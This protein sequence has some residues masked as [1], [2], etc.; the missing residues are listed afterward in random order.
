MLIIGIVWLAF[1]CAALVPVGVRRSHVESMLD[2]DIPI[3]TPREEAERYLTT[4]GISFITDDVNR[5]I[6]ASIRD[7][8]GTLLMTTSIWIRISYDADN[9]VSKIVVNEV[10]TN[11]P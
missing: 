5:I 1:T 7:K 8:S 10:S 6:Y 2:R 3:G 4:K 9:A 11:M